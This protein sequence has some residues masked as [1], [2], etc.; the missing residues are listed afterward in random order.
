MISKVS[1]VILLRSDGAALLQHRDNKPGLARAGMWV[2]PGGHGD[3]SESPEHCAR[4][5]MEEET[6]YRCQ[7]LTHLRTMRDQIDENRV[8]ELSLFLSLYDGKQP[9][10]CREGQELRFVTRIAA[11]NLPMPKILLEVWD[12][13]LQSRL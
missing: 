9:Y 4:R 2:F 11:E 5:E 3:P 10:E 13:I 8:Q 12:D 6:G 1:A 7:D